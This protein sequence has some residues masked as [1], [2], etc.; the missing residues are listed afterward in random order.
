MMEELNQKIVEL[1]NIV[2]NIRKH[3][4]VTCFDIESF[5][6]TQINSVHTWDSCQVFEVVDVKNED[7]FIP[8]HAHPM[9][10][11]VIYQVKGQTTF[12]DGT[13]L[14]DGELR[15]IPAGQ[16]HSLNVSSG[17][18]FIIILQPVESLE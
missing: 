17:S 16:E 9:S 15:I 3:N 4:G 11:E 6:A 18:A 7:M 14:R 8:S 10:Q 2:S 13:I 1:K 12:D 5:L